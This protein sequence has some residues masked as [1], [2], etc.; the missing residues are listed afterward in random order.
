MVLVLTQSGPLGLVS[1]SAHSCLV[2]V[3]VLVSVVLTTTVNTL[4]LATICR[5]SCSSTC[6]HTALEEKREERMQ[7][8]TDPATQAQQRDILLN[9]LNGTVDVHIKIF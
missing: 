3:S 9:S 6:F 1:A 5:Q 8:G 2:Q 7:E 4:R